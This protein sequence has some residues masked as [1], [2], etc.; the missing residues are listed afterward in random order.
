[1]ELLILLGSCQSPGG[2]GQRKAE[3]EGVLPG[4]YVKPHIAS[5]EV[6]FPHSSRMMK[7]SEGV[8]VSQ[9]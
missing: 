1:M 6:F 2:G 7:S 3:L 4:A 9:A 8:P 5:S